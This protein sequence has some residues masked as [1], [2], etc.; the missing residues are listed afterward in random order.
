MDSH[1]GAVTTA[2]FKRL[3]RAV[4]VRSMGACEHCRAAVIE[5]SGFFNSGHLDHF[6]GRGAGRPAESVENCWF[7]CM[8]CDHEKTTN[9]PSNSTW[10]ERFRAHCTAHTFT[11]QL[12]PIEARLQWNAAKGLS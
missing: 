6:W 2:A 5:E 8:K 9:K 12:E 4:F 1:R 11:S 10:L 7:L 3:R